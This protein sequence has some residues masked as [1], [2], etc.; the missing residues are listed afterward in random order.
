MTLA[1]PKS[2]QGKFILVLAAIAATIAVLGA[3]NLV[4]NA[5]ATI[6]GGATVTVTDNLTGVV[7][8]GSHHHS[9][10]VA[11]PRREAGSHTVRPRDVEVDDGREPFRHRRHGHEQ[12]HGVQQ[13][14]SEPTAVTARR[15]WAALIRITGAVTPPVR[16]PT[17][18]SVGLTSFFR[19][20]ATRPPTRLPAVGLT[21]CVLGDAGGV[22]LNCTDRT[23]L[24]A[25]GPLGPVGG[26]GD[27]AGCRG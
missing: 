24:M 19:P 26:P 5:S 21:A 10:Q 27:L 4:N 22:T 25:V 17:A 16:F 1:A 2:R 6:P 8:L 13:R 3:L 18:S 7:P 14:R 12:R 23:E 15:W 11:S 20:P 9:H